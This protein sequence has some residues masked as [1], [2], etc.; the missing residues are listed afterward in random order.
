MYR[1]AV[2]YQKDRDDLRKFLPQY[3]WYRA[4]DHA[5][6]PLALLPTKSASGQANF[7]LHDIA[8]AFQLQSGGVV[9]PDTQK[10]EPL[11][12]SAKGIT[13]S[14]STQV[15]SQQETVSA[16]PSLAPSGSGLQV[17]IK[18][19]KKRSRQEHSYV[20]GMSS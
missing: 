12:D 3:P 9:L 2:Y 15:H 13:R 20:T 5:L 4:D 16:A 19:G 14:G 1:I 18:L 17:K 10:G 8:R 7:Q 6:A 11:N